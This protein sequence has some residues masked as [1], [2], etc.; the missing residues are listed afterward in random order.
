MQKTPALG[1]NWLPRLRTASAMTVLLAIMGCPPAEAPQVDFSNLS[2]ARFQEAYSAQVYLQNYRGPAAFT[3][4]GGEL[5]PGLSMNEAGEISGSPEYLGTYSFDLLISG[6]DSFEDISATG[7]INVVA[8]QETLAQAFIGYE[9]DQANNM[10]A[11]LN[12]MRDIWLRVTGGGIQAEGI[13]TWKINPGIYLPGPNGV[14]NGGDEDDERIGDMTFTELLEVDGV[15][16]SDWEATGPV[17]A[18]P[19]S[20]PSEHVPEDDPPRISED[21]TFSS[22]ADGGEAS[23]RLSHP[24]FS[25]AVQRKVMVIPPD[26]CPE[27][28]DSQG[29]PGGWS[30]TRYCEGPK[31]TE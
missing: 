13:N 5:P 12:M 29:G 26:W 3:Q 30:T 8:S 18:N 7:S 4:V 19:P 14:N 25:G 17:E 20:H 24:D 10:T 22:G 15:E 28:E 11:T 31:P 6:L 2:D 1:R 23:L 9:H 21:G 16:F 27:G